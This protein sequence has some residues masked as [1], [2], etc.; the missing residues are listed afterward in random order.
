MRIAVRD[1]NK[2]RQRRVKFTRSKVE[3][4]FMKQLRN[5]RMLQARVMD[6]R[7]PLMAVYGVPRLREPLPVPMRQL[8]VIHGAA[9]PL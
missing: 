3:L 9:R 6:L 4:E 1:R 2:T 8:L 5:T 7:A